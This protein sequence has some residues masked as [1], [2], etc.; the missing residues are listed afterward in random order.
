[1]AIIPWTRARRLVMSPSGAQQ[2]NAPFILSVFEGVSI[3]V[4]VS[5]GN[6]CSF[7]VQL[8]SLQKLQARQG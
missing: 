4:R 1:M 3:G 7:T 2:V 8:A 6:G 5:Q